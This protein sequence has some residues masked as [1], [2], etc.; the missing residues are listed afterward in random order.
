MS[1]NVSKLDDAR[2]S[3][4]DPSIASIPYDGYKRRSRFNRRVRFHDAARA[5]G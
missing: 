5:D 4:D 3:C 2:V 1:L